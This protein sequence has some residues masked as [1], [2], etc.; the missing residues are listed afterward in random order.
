MSRQAESLGGRRDARKDSRPRVDCDI[1]RVRHRRLRLLR[2]P[3]PKCRCASGLAMTCVRR[4]HAIQGFLGADGEQIC[5]TNPIRA[6]GGWEEAPGG[7]GPSVKY[8][9]RSQF[10]GQSVRNEP[11]L[12]RP[13]GLGG[14]KCAKRSQTWVDWGIWKKGVVVW[15]A[16]RPRSEM[17]E[18]NPISPG[19]RR[20]DG[21]K[22][23]KR[24]QTWGK[25]GMWA[26]WIVVWGAARRRSEMCK[27]N[28]ICRRR[29][30]A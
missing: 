25:W 8:A 9:K 19:R 16:A 2:R 5:K 21:G 24:S 28:L 26:K 13:Q 10:R 18:T 6:G 14:G 12:A 30:A 4:G 7:R 1:E 3:R 22:Y 27:T 17:C 11:N 20:A 15:G 29:A 23:A